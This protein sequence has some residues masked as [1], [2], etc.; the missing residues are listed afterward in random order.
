MFPAG[1]FGTRADMMMDFVIVAFIII[2]PCLVWSW[3]K[4]RKYDFLSHSHMQLTLGG[5]LG[6]AVIIF[7]VDLSMA[8]GMDA[9]TKDSAYHGTAWLNGWIYSHTIIAILTTILWV[10]LLIASVRKFKLPPKSN[11]FK[12]IHRP[13]GYAAMILM[14]ATGLTSFPLYYYGFMM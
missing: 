12:K 8:G 1:F 11:K 2:L 10:Y 14:F 3:I 6:I 4:A 5:I 13:A 7:E 9:L